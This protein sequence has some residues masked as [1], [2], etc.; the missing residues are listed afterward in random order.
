MRTEANRGYKEGELVE[1]G[2]DDAEGRKNDSCGGL[3]QRIMVEGNGTTTPR[4]SSG[5][6]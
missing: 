4:A 5:A 6:R 3:R 2:E 1:L